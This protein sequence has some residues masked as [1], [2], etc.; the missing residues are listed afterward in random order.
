MDS[1]RLV[2]VRNNKSNTEIGVST[3]NQQKVE[4]N[5]K[6]NGRQEMVRK[7]FE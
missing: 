6:F 2:L 7:V 1:P 4:T 5:M 3:F